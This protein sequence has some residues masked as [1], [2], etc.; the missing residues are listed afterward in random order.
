MKVATF[1]RRIVEDELALARRRDPKALHERACG[2]EAHQVQFYECHCDGPSWL[3]AQCKARLQL[4]EVLDSTPKSAKEARRRARESLK[5]LAWPYSGHPDYQAS[6]KPAGAPLES[7]AWQSQ[8]GTS[9]W[10]PGRTQESNPP[11]PSTPKSPPP[12][13]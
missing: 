9:M 10:F 5:I 3:S 7:I 11:T 6:F 4:I 12:D 2:Y 8:P 13:P 1:L